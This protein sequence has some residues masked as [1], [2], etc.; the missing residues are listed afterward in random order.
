MPIIVIRHEN[1]ILTVYAN[2]D[3]VKV[4]KGDKVQR[5]QTIASLSSIDN[6]AYV[7]FEVRDGF[8]S[9]DPAPYLK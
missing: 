1:N 2:V 3:D 6:D 4:T 7:H 5:N 8:D 9:V